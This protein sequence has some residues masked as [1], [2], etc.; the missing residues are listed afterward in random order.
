MNIFFTLAPSGAESVDS[1]DGLSQWRTGLL[2]LSAFIGFYPLLSLLKQ[3]FFF[4][5]MDKI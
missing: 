2:F 5:N 3:R 4:C 1:I